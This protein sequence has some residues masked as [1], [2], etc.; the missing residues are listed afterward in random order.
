MHHMNPSADS[1]TCW[2]EIDLGRLRANLRQVREALPESTPVIAVVKADAYGHGAVEVSQVLTDEGVDI[3]GVATVA[4][5]RE[6]VEAGIDNRIL[7]LGRL[8]DDQVEQALRWG[9]EITVPRLELART[10]SE[11]A[12]RKGITVPVHLKVDTGMTRLGVN[13]ETAHEDA[14]V[15]AELPGLK[16]A[17]VLTHFANADL[18]DKAFCRIQLDR[19]AAVREKLEKTGITTTFHMANSAAILTAT[20]PQDTGARPGLMLYGSAPA[21]GLDEGHLAP[22]LSWKCRVLQVRDV[23]EG[24]G[25][26]YGHDYIT[27][28]DRILATI[29]VGYADGFMRCLSN[30][31]QVLIGGQRA[32]VVGRVTMDMTIV[33]ITDIPRVAA[34]DEVVIIGR[35]GDDCITAEEMASWA[36]T[37]NYEVY[38]AISCRVKRVFID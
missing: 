23:P 24:I 37:I 7:L 15:V 5:A 38:C 2:T 36:D 26:S 34:G 28:S 18:A 9:V 22:I 19:F 3:L 11:A 10:I 14:A 1:S 30:T 35:Q 4:E 8:V 32:P 21:E 13:W 6:L 33:D 12:V 29:S 20:N 31:G 16:L 27:E 17:G 25:V